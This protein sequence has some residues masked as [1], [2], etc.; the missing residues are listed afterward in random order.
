MTKSFSIHQ[1]SLVIVAVAVMSGYSLR[2][3]AQ[4][5][6]AENIDEEIGRAHV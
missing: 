6:T 5:L 2:M 3:S 1:I 4:T